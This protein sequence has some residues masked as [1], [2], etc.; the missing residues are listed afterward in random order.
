M[1]PPPEGVGDHDVALAAERGEVL[2]ALGAETLVRPVV[3][4][5]LNQRR[6]AIADAA[7]MAREV[8]FLMPGGTVAPRGAAEVVGIIEAAAFS[9]TDAHDRSRSAPVRAARPTAFGRSASSAASS[10]ASS[11][12]SPP[13]PFR[14]D[15]IS[16]AFHS[17]SVLETV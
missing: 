1:L 13:A 15:R 11:S 5:D 10:I 3:D 12:G 6:P 4:L 9:L 16:P 14:Q 8:Q 17:R 7:P 2:D